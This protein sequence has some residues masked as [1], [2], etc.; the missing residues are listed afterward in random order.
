MR[1]S[2]TNGNGRRLRARSSGTVA[3]TIAVVAV[4]VAIGIAILGATGVAR[5]NTRSTPPDVPETAQ[6]TTRTTA[7]TG[8]AASVAAIESNANACAPAG[9]KS[10]TCLA[11]GGVIVHGAGVQGILDPNEI[12]R[13]FEADLPAQWHSVVRATIDAVEYLPGGEA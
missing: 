10:G 5:H 11:G 8:E 1:R 13:S 12:E 6:P 2:G 9:R 3:T 4:G 7:G